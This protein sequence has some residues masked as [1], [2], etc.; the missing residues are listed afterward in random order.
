MSGDD[1]DDDLVEELFVSFAQ[2]ESG[3]W[4]GDLT[5]ASSGLRVVIFYVC[6]RSIDS[7]ANRMLR[8]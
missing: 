7:S 2:G 8:H 4:T 5:H 3:L 1:N 6:A